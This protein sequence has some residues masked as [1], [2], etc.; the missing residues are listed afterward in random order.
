L[1]VSG[2]ILKFSKGIERFVHALFTLLL[3]NLT[4]TNSSCPKCYAMKFI[5]ADFQIFL[6]VS[7][8]KKAH[9]TRTAPPTDIVQLDLIGWVLALRVGAFVISPHLRQEIKLED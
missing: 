6:C 5:L 3:N 8:R 1:R 4:L 7:H 9:R 2:A